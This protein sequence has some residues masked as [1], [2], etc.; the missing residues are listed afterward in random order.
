MSFNY[1]PFD[2]TVGF[3]NDGV[4]YGK[5]TYRVLATDGDQAENKAL[6]SATGSEF[7]DDRFAGRRIVIL[8]CEEAEDQAKAA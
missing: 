1:I 3:K 6:A 4:I 7:N 8:E 5:E 2:V